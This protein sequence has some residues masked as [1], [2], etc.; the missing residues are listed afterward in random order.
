MAAVSREIISGPVMQFLV[1]GR[2]EVLTTTPEVP[3]VVISITDHGAP[4]AIVAPSAN[5][6]GI[7]RLQFHDADTAQA[8]RVIITEE[9]AQA[10]TDFVQQHRAQAQLIICQCEAGISR[11]SGVAAALS[12]WLNGSDAPFFRHYVPNRLVYRTVLEAAY[13]AEPEA[14]G[15]PTVA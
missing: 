5:Q 1:L 9:N 4:Q 11:S 8:D 7:L 13:Q 12:K 10:I 6:R 15:H 14:F 3:Y 2:A